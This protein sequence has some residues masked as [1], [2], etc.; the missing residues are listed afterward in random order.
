[1]FISMKDST[2]AI[3]FTVLV[4]ALAVGFSFIPGIGGF[5]YMMTPTIA[6]LLMMLVITRHGYSKSGWKRL[7]LHKLGMR[8]WA[9]VLIVPIIPLA[10]GF[11]IV[12]ATGLASFAPGKDFEGFPWSIFPLLFVFI[13][14][15]AVLTQSLGEELGWRGYLLPL[16]MNCMGRKKAMLLNGVIHGVWHF[17]L[18]TMTQAY[19][20]GEN[21]W[22]L[23]PLTVLSTTFLAPVIGEIRLRSGSVWTSSMMHT[24]HN[25]VWMILGV[26][27]V[28]HSEMTA[29]LSGDMSIIIVLFYL[30]LTMYMWRRPISREG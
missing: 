20:A 1:M 11:G 16:M 26:V 18:I 17:P 13:Y 8:N 30:G 21:L 25:L 12:W 15:K 27:T 29:Y 28:N 14:V 2:K 23:L 19:H 5:G 22:L 7:G 3:I 9:F 6:V 10:I 24:T 4:L